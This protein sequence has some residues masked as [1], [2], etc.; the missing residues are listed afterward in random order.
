MITHFHIFIIFDVGGYL[1]SNNLKIAI[2][3]FSN[4]FFFFSSRKI[5]NRRRLSLM[6]LVDIETTL[7][8]QRRISRDQAKFILKLIDSS[9]ED[10]GVLTDDEDGNS[11]EDEEESQVQI[12]RGVTV[13]S[14]GVNIMPGGVNVMKGGTYVAAGGM[15]FPGVEEILPRIEQVELNANKILHVLERVAPDDKT[16]TQQVPVEPD[17]TLAGIEEVPPDN[18]A[19]DTD[20]I[21]VQGKELPD[22]ALVTEDEE[23]IL[24]SPKHIVS[25]A[26]NVVP[27]GIRKSAL[28]FFKCC[29]CLCNCCIKEDETKKN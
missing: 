19:Q 1:K 11:S 5:I 22:K 10:L 7:N 12:R 28:Q 26:E 24:P 3:I 27:G 14:G 20:Q 8:P 13:M 4:L 18:E 2:H 25:G 6:K 9:P 29:P 15:H 21:Q 23:E 17:E 16:D